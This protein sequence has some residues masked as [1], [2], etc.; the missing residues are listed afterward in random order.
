MSV[1]DRK[2]EIRTMPLLFILY[3]SLVLAICKTFPCVCYYYLLRCLS[4][5]LLLCPV[6]GGASLTISCFER[7]RQEAGGW[8]YSPPGR[9]T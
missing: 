2:R 4:S 9:Q 8:S 3:V 7:P 5:S 1:H 6:D